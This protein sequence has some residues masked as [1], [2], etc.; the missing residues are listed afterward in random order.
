MNNTKKTIEYS[1]E[2]MKLYIQKHSAKIA[3]SRESLQNLLNKIGEGVESPYVPRRSYFLRY[4]K[5]LVGAF[6]LVLVISSGALYVNHIT[7]PV[8]AVQNSVQLAPTT[9]VA[10]SDI[11]D[12]GLANDVSNIDTQM[13][14]LDSD[15][16]DI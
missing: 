6:A 5:I 2:E 12:Q 14:G 7:A 16:Q 4:S 8:A 15:I 13:N 1:D 3:P 11:S 9:Q 10:T